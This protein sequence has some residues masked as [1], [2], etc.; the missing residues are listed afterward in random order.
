MYADTDMDDLDVFAILDGQDD[1]FCIGDSPGQLDLRA[2]SPT[3]QDVNMADSPRSICILADDFYTP[4]I[5][6]PLDISLPDHVSPLSHIPGSPTIPLDHTQDTEGFDIPDLSPS[7]VER[8]TQAGFDIPALSPS[9]VECPTQAAFDIPTLSPSPVDR[10]MQAGF[11]I[12]DL[13]PRPQDDLMDMCKLSSFPLTKPDLH[14]ISNAQPEPG[15]SSVETQ[16]DHECAAERSL[17]T[18]KQ[19]LLPHL[20]ILLTRTSLLRAELTQLMMEKEMT[21][22]YLDGAVTKILEMDRYL[23]GLRALQRIREER[24][25]D[26]EA[27]V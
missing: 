12:P 21:T 26:E 6:N 23:N 25:R 1:L 16:V 18:L 7:P 27:G 2:P 4:D 3:E 14:E 11:D 22:C 15:P 20:P 19:N 10:P 9:P 5:T 24:V 8:P 13:S 17:K